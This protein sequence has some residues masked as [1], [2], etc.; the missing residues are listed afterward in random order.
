MK[1]EILLPIATAPTYF[2]VNTATQERG[3]RQAEALAEIRRRGVWLT[4]EERELAGLPALG[5]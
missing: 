2:V 3:P 4:R 1:S 5:K